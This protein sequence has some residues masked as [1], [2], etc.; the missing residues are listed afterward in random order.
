V[1]D[2]N[3]EMIYYFHYTLRT[4]CGLQTIS[5]GTRRSLLPSALI[6]DVRSFVVQSLRNTM[7]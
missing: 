1:L 7:T 3:L 5:C 6:T 4:R 2:D